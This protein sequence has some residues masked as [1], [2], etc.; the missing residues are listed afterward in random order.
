[1]DTKKT[2]AAQALFIIFLFFDF[3]NYKKKQTTH[4]T[5]TCS[6]NAYVPPYPPGFLSDTDTDAVMEMLSSVINEVKSDISMPMSNLATLAPSAGPGKA[7]KIHPVTTKVDY[8][9]PLLP[10]PGVTMPM[11][12][13]QFT[14][15]P[16]PLDIVNTPSTW[17]NYNEDVPAKP[18]ASA[19]AHPVQPAP[20][21][22]VRIVDPGSPSPPI[23]AS[24]A[25]VSA[26]EAAPTATPSVEQPI[27]QAQSAVEK[28]TVKAMDTDPAIPPRAVVD[29]KLVLVVT[30]AGSGV[31]R[32]SLP[33]SPLLLMQ[34]LARDEKNRSH[35][36]KPSAPKSPTK[37]APTPTKT[38]T[39][40]VPEKRTQEPQ[41]KTPVNKTETSQ[42]QVQQPH[43]AKPATPS[44]LS[45][46]APRLRQRQPPPPPPPPAP[47]DPPTRRRSPTR[48]AAAEACAKI[49][50]ASCITAEEI[51]GSDDDGKRETPTS[52]EQHPCTGGKHIS[53]ERLR[54]VTDNNERHSD[55]ADDEAE[56]QRKRKSPSPVSADQKRRRIE[57]RTKVQS[58]VMIRIATDETHTSLFLRVRP[59]S[60]TDAQR[61]FLREHPSMS[62]HSAS[63]EDPTG[64]LATVRESVEWWN[65]FGMHRP[66]K[67]APFGKTKKQCL[68]SSETMDAPLLEEGIEVCIAI[69]LLRD[70]SAQRD[71]L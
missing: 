41:K 17:L 24:G 68:I 9:L 58:T 15:P 45:K 44:P 59:A 8:D 2:K 29:Q 42:R 38:L 35:K 56:I 53:P 40:K 48:K 5:A 10:V 43:K 71:T 66:D 34:R 16:T 47:K 67:F 32:K 25:T 46:E 39:P 49:L 33:P 70:R 1:M 7:T 64:I 23:V 57:D 4:M 26:S 19:Y 31:H 61:N 3:K 6:T 18:A 36:K 22:V 55:D 28:Q 20:S 50:D 27:P 62:I 51:D 60:L 54:E 30:A 65:T 21:R 69:Y 11:A 13:D 37:Q 12:V 52:S 63:S 14:P